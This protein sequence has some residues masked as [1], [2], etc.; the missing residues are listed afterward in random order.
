MREPMLDE[1]LEEPIIRKVMLADGYSAED[2]RLL[3]RQA[4]AR[5]GYTD[6]HAPRDFKGLSALDC[7]KGQAG[8][9]V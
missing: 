4:G 9:T 8:V 5:T 6:R 2:I 3:I 1:L 7:C